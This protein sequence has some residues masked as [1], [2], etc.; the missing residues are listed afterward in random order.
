MRILHLVHSLRRGG[1]ERILLDLSSAFVNRGHIVDV[2]SL[3]A[4]DEYHDPDYANIRRHY[5]IQPDKYRWPWGIPAMARLLKSAVS[6][7][8]PDVMMIHTPNVAWVA[9]AAGCR[10]PSVQMLHGYGAM[11]SRLSGM[12]QWLARLADQWAF[13]RLGRRLAVV[14][15]SMVPVAATHFG[16]SESLVVC[17][18][19][20]VDLLRFRWRNRT[21]PKNPVILTVGTMAR[22]KRPDLV[23]SAL[24]RLL[25]HW[26]GVRLWMV[27][28]GP[29][30]EETKALAA[31][32]G[33]DGQVEFLGRRDDVPDLMSRAHVFWQLSE[34]EGLPRSV[35]EAM[36]TGLPVVGHDV[37]GIRDTVVN[38]QTGFLVPFG[39]VESVARKT[40]ELLSQPELY[41]TFSVAA[42]AGRSR[43]SVCSG[44]F[45]SMK[46]YC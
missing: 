16:C 43:N 22:V 42:R 21:L 34:S 8:Y 33:I 4:F 24:A 39:D 44:W 23:V 38:S 30:H 5:I 17:V 32:M 41:K 1:A 19:N 18:P 45:L 6:Q 12:K 29:S 13:R 3:I 14:S 25:P 20:G 31:R 46:H 26:P 15:R 7:I 27:G 36:A 10:V 2:L 11:T 35:L 40:N 37:R 28:D 9:A